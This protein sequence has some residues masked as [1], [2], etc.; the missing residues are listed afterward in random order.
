MVT[1]RFREINKE[2]VDKLL[3]AGDAPKDKFLVD[4]KNKRAF[5]LEYPAYYISGV[6]I[7][8]DSN[9][10]TSFSESELL[11][12]L[13]SGKIKEK[14]GK[15]LSNQKTYKRFMGTMERL[16]YTVQGI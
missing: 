14:A 9:Y 4:I 10:K 15:N 13:L 7:D 5:L 1:L 6:S 16:L 11:V 3:G 2:A 8:K 12:N